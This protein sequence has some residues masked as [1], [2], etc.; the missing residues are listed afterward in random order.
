[1]RVTLDRAQ[2][3]HALSTVTKAV[4][5]RTTIPI[6]GNVLLSA[7]KGQLSI[8]GTNLDLEISTSLPVLDSQDG[9]VTVAGK[10][11]LDIAKKATG[12]VLLEADGNHLVVKSGKSRFKLDTL[13]AADFPSFNHGSFDTTIEID[14]A[15]LVQSVQF[16]VSTEETR[17]Y[18]NGVFLEAKDGHIVATATDGHRLA[19]TRIEQEATFASVILPNKLLSLLPTGVVSVSLSSNKVMVE[20]GSTVIVSKLVD[21]TYPD[22]ERVIPKPSERVA[23][24]S[25]K[26]LREAVGRTSV[27]ASERGKAV[28]FSFASDALTLNVANPDRGDATE[29]M[30]VN[31]SSEPLTI[32]F[33]GQ[34]VTDLMS[35]FGTD[36]VTMSM[37]DSGS[38]ALITAAS[39]PGYRC[40]I[41]PMR[42]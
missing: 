23:T 38:P 22:Y 15:S 35:A 1:M 4:E 8:T 17:Y 31:F 5:A 34:Y 39:K 33:N 20:S 12:D 13:P 16:A 28:R 14:L 37:A 40:V 27:I 19:S 32:G 18:L 29:E 6:L 42:V 36:E 3:A 10:L 24:L 21:G 25:A 30:E 2:L 41:M 9:T 7:D 26:A 11:L